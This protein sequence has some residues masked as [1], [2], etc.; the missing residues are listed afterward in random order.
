MTKDDLNKYTAYCWNENIFIV[1]KPITS[2]G[3]IC[4]IL[5]INK[6]KEKVGEE[7]Y[8]NEKVYDKIRELYQ[9]IYEANHKKI[10]K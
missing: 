1:P 9:K 3:S 2:N 4:K 5:M 8:S 6:G 10:E 7:K